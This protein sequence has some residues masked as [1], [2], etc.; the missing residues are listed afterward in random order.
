MRTVDD[1][2]ILNKWSKIFDERPHRTMDVSP[3][4]KVT[5]YTIRC[6]STSLHYNALTYSHYKN[7]HD[8]WS[9]DPLYTL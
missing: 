6:I 1:N 9:K 3:A 7:L 2:Y 5:P 8:G 4:I